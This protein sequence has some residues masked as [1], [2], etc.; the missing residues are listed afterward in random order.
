MR[1]YEDCL[2]C[3]ENS[4]SKEKRKCEVVPSDL[5]LLA[6]NEELN[7]DFLVWNQKNVLVIV[8]RHSGF[9]YAEITQK[10]TTDCA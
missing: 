7:M 6:P 1:K 9:V 8:D 5:T 4:V 2:D 3:K 10:Q